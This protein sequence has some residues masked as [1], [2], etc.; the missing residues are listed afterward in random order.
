MFAFF[1]VFRLETS[2]YKILQNTIK[3]VYGRVEDQHKY[4][5]RT[6]S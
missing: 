3:L 5:D 4:F 2:K 1:I 6:N